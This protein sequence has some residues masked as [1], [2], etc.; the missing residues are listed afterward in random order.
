MTP[1]AKRDR[2]IAEARQMKA[3]ADRRFV[4]GETTREQ[5]AAAVRRA[6]DAATWAW[7]VFHAEVQEANRP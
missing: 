1:A 5:H 7:D 6:G 3:D 2:A 4:R